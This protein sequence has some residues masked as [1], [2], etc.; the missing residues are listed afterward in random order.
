MDVG[1]PG[2]R[3]DG[4]SVLHLVLLTIEASRGSKGT[5]VVGVRT[6]LVRASMIHEVRRSG[7]RFTMKTRSAPIPRIFCSLASRRRWTVESFLLR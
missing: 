6:A 4:R 7:E 3:A 1:R 2:G 5:S